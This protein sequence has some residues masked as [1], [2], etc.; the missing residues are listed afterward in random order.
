MYRVGLG[1]VRKV[2]GTFGTQMVNKLKLPIRRLQQIHT[3]EDSSNKRSRDLNKVPVLTN[4][5]ECQ[6]I[7][8]DIM[9][10]GNQAIGLDCE[11]LNLGDPKSGRLTLVQISTASGDIHLF[12]VLSNPALMNCDKGLRDLLHSDNITKVLHSCRSDALQIYIDF[13]ITL[14]PIYD[15]QLAYTLIQKQAGNIVNQISYNNICHEHKLPVNISKDVM[16]NI[17][18]KDQKFWLNRPLTK[19]MVDYA[20][21]DVRSLLKIRESQLNQLTEENKILVETECNKLVQS[22]V[23]NNKEFR[24]QKSQKKTTNTSGVK[25]TNDFRDGKDMKLPKKSKS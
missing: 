9:S 6:Q 10:G 19:Q 8:Q 22:L 5:Q 25:R 16:K 7:V 20:R 24:L 13:G 15:T 18:R 12:D 3:V 1:L 4:I 23:H 11:G 17:Y 2:D 21:E 14:Q